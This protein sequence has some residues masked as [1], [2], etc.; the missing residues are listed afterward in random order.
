MQVMWVST[1]EVYEKPIVQYGRL[2][3][4]LKHEEAG[5]YTTYNVGHFGFHGRIYKAIMKGL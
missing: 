3:T 2:P 5:T 4:S 1:P